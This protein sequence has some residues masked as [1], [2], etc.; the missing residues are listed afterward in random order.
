MS[1]KIELTFNEEGEIATAI[2]LATVEELVAAS[3]LLIDL[4]SKSEEEKNKKKE[5]CYVARRI[6]SLVPGTVRHRS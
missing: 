4:I 2:V 1:N 3:L 6:Q 5:G